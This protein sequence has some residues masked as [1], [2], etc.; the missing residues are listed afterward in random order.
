MADDSDP[1]ATPAL[2][3]YQRAEIEMERLVPVL[4]R[5]Q[6]ALGEEAVLDALRSDLD[7][8]IAEA[9]AQAEAEGIRPEMTWVS[10]GFERFARG[11]ALEYDVVADDDELVGVDVT[12]CEYAALMDRLDAR[13]LGAI[14]LCGQDHVG[15]ARRGLR[16]D[17]PRTHMQG[18]DVCDFR[19]TP[20]ELRSRQTG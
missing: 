7:A 3:P 4:R 9:S 13:D 12:R 6:A 18:H 1:T 20:V 10:P 8:R 5:L 15:A 17:R 19:F 11:D 2:T 16:L 14:L